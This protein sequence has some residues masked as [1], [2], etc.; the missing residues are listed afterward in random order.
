MAWQLGLPSEGRRSRR[1]SPARRFRRCQT[2][3]Q[4]RFDLFAT[5]LRTTALGHCGRLESTNCGRSRQP[6]TSHLGRE[7]AF[8]E[9][10]STFLGDWNIPLGVVVFVTTLG[11]EAAAN[12]IDVATRV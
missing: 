11:R 1:T 3:A 6:G 9:S 5:P 4:G 12:L 10:D 2:T 7:R 8:R